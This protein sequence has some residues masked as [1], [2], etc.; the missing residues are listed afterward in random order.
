MF[1][2]LSFYINASRKTDHGVKK[3]DVRIRT[4]AGDKKTEK[5]KPIKA[6]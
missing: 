6:K 2:R 5:I 3:E 4:R 1:S